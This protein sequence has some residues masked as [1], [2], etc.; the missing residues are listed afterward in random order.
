MEIR[1]KGHNHAVLRTSISQ[2][3][4]IFGCAIADLAHMQR[5]DADLGQQGCCRTRQSLI[6]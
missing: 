6:K 2:N 5:V 1:V 4:G 3:V